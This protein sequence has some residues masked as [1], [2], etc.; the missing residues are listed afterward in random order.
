MKLYHHHHHHHHHERCRFKTVNFVL[1]KSFV[2]RLSF[3]LHLLLGWTAS[4]SPWVHIVVLHL[5]NDWFPF[6]LC[7]KATFVGS[8]RSHPLYCFS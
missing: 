2:F 3:S 4:L 8:S 1:C 5:V 6:C 7:V